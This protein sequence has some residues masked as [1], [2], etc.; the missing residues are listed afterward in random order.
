MILVSN[1]TTVLD[2]LFY[3]YRVPVP[4]FSKKG[5]HLVKECQ[6][7]LELITAVT[8]LSPNQPSRFDDVTPTEDQDT[9]EFASV[10]RAIRAKLKSLQNYTLSLITSIFCHVFTITSEP[11]EN[12][13][14]VY[15]CFQRNP[16]LDFRPRLQSALTTF[17]SHVEDISQVARLIQIS[18]ANPNIYRD[19][20]PCLSNFSSVNS[21]IVTLCAAGSANSDYESELKDEDFMSDLQEEWMTTFKA[22]LKCCALSLNLTHFTTEVENDIIR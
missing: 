6:K 5:N 16:K 7:L 14:K 11:L 10:C 3:I 17:Q 1:Y 4:R 15:D 9:S 8:K 21:Q 2:Q 12:L 20:R 18:C 13:T 19:F 22:L